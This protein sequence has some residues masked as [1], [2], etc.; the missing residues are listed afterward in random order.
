VRPWQDVQVKEVVEKWARVFPKL[1]GRRGISGGH[2]IDPELRLEALQNCRALLPLEIILKVWATF[3]EKRSLDIEQWYRLVVTRHLP[4]KM[5]LD[6]A[7]PLLSRLAILQYEEGFITRARMAALGI[8]EEAATQP[9]PEDI[10]D[11]L[12]ADLDADARNPAKTVEQAAKNTVKT[13]SNPGAQLLLK[14]RRSG[15]LVHY[16]G[17]RYRFWNNG[18]AAYLAS[19]N[20]DKIGAEN[21]YERSLQPGWSNVIQCLALHTPIDGLVETRLNAPLDVLHW[22]VTDLGHW[23]KY[24]PRSAPWRGHVFRQLTNIMNAP[25]QYPIVRQRAAAALVTAPD[26]IQDLNAL[27]QDRESSVR[28]AAG[29]ALGAVATEEAIDTMIGALSHDEEPVRKAMAEA[30][31]SLPDVGHPILF[32]AVRSPDM[33][34]RRASIAGI[35]R[36]RAN[37][38]MAAIYRAFLLDTEWYVRSAAEDAFIAQ[39]SGGERAALIAQHAPDEIAWLTNWARERGLALPNA[40]N[41]QDLLLQ[42]LKDHEPNIRALAASNLG[43]LGALTVLGPLYQTLCDQ[44]DSVRA[45]S[46]DA[47]GHLQILMGRPLPAP[48]V[49]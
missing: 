25:S 10:A 6:T 3:S 29:M 47:L 12:R 42:A 9:V 46:F 22:T 43:D 31:A 34:T 41:A 40:D 37:W 17:E 39:Q 26:T 24:T 48:A 14:L 49:S 45:A 38:A 21:L 5:T 11:A 30:F 8:Y 44:M 28:V 19:L 32:E 2:K 1:S 7:L 4:K 13:V 15:M 20:L 23:L 35:R 16:G 33:L 18:I 36:I 27:A